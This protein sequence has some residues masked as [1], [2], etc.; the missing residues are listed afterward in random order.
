MQLLYGFGK[1]EGVYLKELVLIGEKG[2]Y[3]KKLFSGEEKYMP[4]ER[5]Y[6][7]FKDIRFE[8][9]KRIE[10]EVTGMKVR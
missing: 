9:I 2:E 4:S 10:I 8:D 5:R 6:Y 3:R 7:N 1:N